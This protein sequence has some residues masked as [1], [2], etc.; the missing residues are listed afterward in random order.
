MPFLILMDFLIEIA[1]EKIVLMYTNEQIFK[2]VIKIRRIV[3]GRV[4]KLNHLFSF[5][6][7]LNSFARLFE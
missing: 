1:Y 7:F 2:G 6:N 4:I 3:F 5:K